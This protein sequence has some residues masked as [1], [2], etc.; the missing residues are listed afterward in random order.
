PDIDEHLIND[1]DNLAPFGMDN[2]KPIFHIEEVPKEVKQ[3]GIQKNHLKMEFDQDDYT[4]S[5]IGFGMGD[6][7]PFI[8]ERAPVSVI[9]EL[10]INEWN[11]NR[12]FQIVMKDLGVNVWQL[13]DHRG[14]KELDLHTIMNEKSGVL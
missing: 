6:L 4:L 14:N 2:P 1:I 8:S 12:K 10:G 9:G 3:I 5:G 11:G 13:F 7:F